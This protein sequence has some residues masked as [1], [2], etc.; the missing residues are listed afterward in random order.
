MPRT[1]AAV[2][3]P[4]AADEVL[5]F[6]AHRLDIRHQQLWRGA[7][8]VALQPKAWALLLVLVHR[9]G[10][11]VSIDALLNALWPGVEVTHKALTNRIV[12]L[13]KALGDDPQ[14]PRL[15]QTV[16][17]RGYRWLA[18]V[19]RGEA[20]A[21]TAVT[22][23]APGLHGAG[24]VGGAGHAD[25][26]GR[27][28]ERAAL[29]QH[30][31]AAGQATRQLVLL[32]GEA[33]MGKTALVDAFARA[34]QGSQAAGA[35]VLAGRGASLQQSSEREAFGPLLALVADLAAG[36]DRD[37]VVP[38]LR[39]CAPTWLLQL[40]WLGDEADLA[41]W[42][43]N[44]AGAG[45]GRMV[46]E[47]CAFFEALA[48]QR[49]LLLLLDDLQWA[50]PATID[51]LDQ[52]AQ[53]RRPA[54][55]MVLATLQSALPQ[56]APHPLRAR[57]HRLVVQGQLH[58]LALG[59]LT[60]PELQAHLSARFGSA[61]LAHTLAS[62]AMRASGGRPLFLAAMI[63]HLLAAGH[64]RQGAQGWV[65]AS[66]GGAGAAHT[67]LD[68]S[69]DLGAADALR[70]L[71]A[72]ALAQLEPAQRTLL[73]AASV[74]GMQVSAQG[75]AAALGLAPDEVE[76]A[77][78]ALVQRQPWLVP[79]AAAAWP[80]GSLAQ[81]WTFVHE[82][83]R[84]VLY[85]AIPPA[86]RQL[87]HRRVAER[88]ARGWQARVGEQA[89]ALAAAYAQA[90]M[91]EATAR[92]LE[93]V[94]GVCAQRYAYADA[95]DAMHAALA[96]LAR[97]PASDARDRHEVR[98]QLTYADLLMAHRGLNF[99]RI[100][101]AFQAAE[102]LSLRL[103]EGRTLMRARLGICLH[104]ILCA[105][106]SAAVAASEGLVALALA[107]QPAQL[108]AAHAYTGLALLLAGHANRAHPHFE[109][110][111][112]LP[113]VPG[114][115]PLL[116]IHALA[117]VQ[118]L[119]CLLAL[120]RTQEAASSLDAA[121]AEARRACVP[122][123]LIQNLF[124]TADCQC[125]LGRR[126]AAAALLDEMLALAEVQALPHYRIAA[127]VCRMGLAPPAQRDL[128]RMDALLQQLLASGERWCDAKL[129]ALLAE[130]RQ[131]HGDLAGAHE[132]LAQA[133]ALLEGMPVHAD[134]V[135]QVRQRLPLA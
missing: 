62:R 59:P 79:R 17:R 128:P 24:V 7:Q 21:T 54:R 43:R 19:R 91:P 95:A 125:R 35:G 107:Q 101:R 108:A 116:D 9:P 10:E 58:E 119:R 29:A 30:W 38:L 20:P 26:A 111:L 117:G 1:M 4:A 93:L 130:T 14:A 129:L 134:E 90:D 33:G 87:L 99:P 66:H 5:H 96:Q 45:N 48:Q 61:N 100:L 11:L 65:L 6:G 51:L 92:M 83:H 50:D 12:E 46:R 69:L 84:Q 106:A 37:L 135:A 127:E 28:A 72:A 132:A 89:G 121:L 81:A 13:R 124:W 31:A 16:H 114:S 126:G 70:Q 109:Q 113:A 76:Q 115:S 41:Q 74:V 3:A 64:L 94:A 78:Q 40:P 71:I 15:I 103:A 23:A 112:S 77:C 75:L 2:P 42:R 8:P 133:E 36:P 102:T 88:L 18:E 63:D 49:P 105:W 82:V 80:D 22:P 122:M 118:R 131:A 52:L 47:G 85:T 120:G 73:E 68:E 104:H 98:L 123:D 97:V 55:L 44:L 60:L 67:G 32:T 34:V 86:R 56:P 110:V 57:V 25:L 39:R 27:S 53:G